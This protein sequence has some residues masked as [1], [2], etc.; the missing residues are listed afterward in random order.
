[1]AIRC[2]RL[3][4]L[5]LLI[6]LSVA[7]ESAFAS[8]PTDMI[9]A[10][11]PA[12][13]SHKAAP[14]RLGP[15]T[16]KG[17]IMLDYETIPVPAGQPLD[18]LG[19]HYLHQLNP[20]LYLGLGLHA[21]L[22]A[23]NYGGFMAIDATIHAQHRLFGHAFI[24]AGASVGGGGG[25]SSIQQSKA[26]SGRGEFIKT[27]IGLGYHFRGFSAGLNYTHFRFMNSLI[28]HAQLDA[29]I[30]RPVSYAIGPYAYSGQ[31]FASDHAFSENGENILTTEL[32]NIVQIHPKGLNKS[33][34]RTLSLQFSHFLSRNRYLFLGVDVG[35]KGLPLYNQALGG[36]GYR[37]S[38][39]P[40]VKVYGQ[41]GIG[42]GG[43]TPPVIDTASGLLVYPKFSVEY[44][45]NRSLGLSLSGG[46][47]FAP[48]G[49]SRN[50][51]LGAAINYHLSAAANGA[52]ASASAGARVYRGFRVHVFQQ[53]DFDVRFGNVKHGNIGFL[54]AQADYI[55]SDHWYVPTQV[56]VAYD[57]VL[58]FAGYGEILTG[59]GVQSRYSASHR[60]QNFFQILVGVDTHGIILKPV[61]GT[62]LGLGD[63]I[64]LYGQFG[65]TISLHGLHLYPDRLRLSSYSVGIGL[66]YRFS[67]PDT[68]AN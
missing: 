37:V 16:A 3:H 36:F 58:G 40:R 60:L 28:N 19:L 30:Q 1:M 41:I 56:S 26:L 21:P 7:A 9:S 2:S 64:A 50:V 25:G 66:T 46:Y 6:L 47:L 61:I 23:G 59:L 10:P 51:T 45:L 15:S 11:A 67:L 31:Q 55:V 49:S 53:T 32:N 52:G 35:Y 12:G 29:F 39:S 8:P 22:F 5:L 17:L 24:D 38:V 20:W 62:D 42:S 68:L 14:G 44:L 57:K 4:P 13:A 48:K 34:I 63:D 18:L 33:T 43:Y 27:Y 54:S 65:K